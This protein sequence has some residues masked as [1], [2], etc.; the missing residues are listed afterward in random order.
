MHTLISIYSVPFH[1]IRFDSIQ[2]IHLFARSFGSQ[3]ADISAKE[4]GLISRYTVHELNGCICLIWYD[5]DRR[6]F[7][8][9]TIC[10]FL[11]YASVEKKKGK[12]QELIYSIFI[13]EQEAY[14]FSIDS[15]H[16]CQNLFQHIFG[17]FAKFTALM[18]HVIH[19]ISFR[20]ERN[21]LQRDFRGE[22]R[23]Q[24]YSPNLFIYLL[25]SNRYT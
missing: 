10:Q 15:L 3:K 13:C 24:T 18:S 21:F 22:E 16:S 17:W 12:L 19:L 2:H 11:P 23:K 1:S 25:S 14:V 8:V 5:D 4:Y 9:A 7:S 6:F 20:L